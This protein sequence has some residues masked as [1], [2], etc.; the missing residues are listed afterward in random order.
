MNT[1]TGDLSRNAPPTPVAILVAP[2]PKVEWQTPG[3]PVI[4][5]DTSAIIPAEASLDVRINSMPAALKASSNG[6][7]GPPGIPK[8]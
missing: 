8:T 1:I 2:G 7:D 3:I 6:I 4:L 5:P